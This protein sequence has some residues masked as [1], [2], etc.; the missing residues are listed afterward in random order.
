MK[1]LLTLLAL[2]FIFPTQADTAKPIQFSH[3]DWEIV[4]DNTRT[5]RAVGYQSDEDELTLS[6]LLTRN[7]GPNKDV[8]AELMIGDTLED[9]LPNT[10]DMKINQQSYGSIKL[11]PDNVT[12]LSNSQRDA[13]L[14][15]LPKTSQ[16]EFI[17]NQTIWRL[18]DRGA[19]AVLLKMDEAQGRL[20]TPGALIRK[21]TEDENKVLAEIPAP[22][23]IKAP[24]LP[25]TALT[26]SQE[27]IQSIEES[28]DSGDC[29]YEDTNDSSALTIYP[30]TD[31][32]WLASR[33]CWLAAYNAGSNYWLIKSTAPYEPVLITDSGTDYDQGVISASH[34]GRGLGDCW[35]YTSWT[36]NGKSFVLSEESTTGMCKMVTAG[37]AWKLPSFVSQVQ[38]AK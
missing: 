12:L 34:K 3:G 15:A 2:V 18:S 9:Q 32:Y 29:D 22:I 20:D 8:T 7:A 36:W 14:K 31:H 30:V 21:G 24:T 35:S 1:Y 37:G 13:L 4:C 11:N 28:L 33:T 10:V 23:I 17:H 16:I 38:G 5:C 25:A 26:L 6:V 27:I 19:A